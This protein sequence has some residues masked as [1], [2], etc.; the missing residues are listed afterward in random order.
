MPLEEV[1]PNNKSKLC[2]HLEGLQHHKNSRKCKSFLRNLSIIW[3]KSR[4]DKTE[5]DCDLFDDEIQYKGY[6]GE[7]MESN[8]D[9]G[10]KVKLMRG[11]TSSSS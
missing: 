5:D 3:E 10:K 7:P 11:Q 9:H 4:L 2:K 6:Q 8:M 1:F